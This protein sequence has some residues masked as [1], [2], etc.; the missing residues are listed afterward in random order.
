MVGAKLRKPFHGI[1]AEKKAGTMKSGVAVDKKKKMVKRKE[2]YSLYIYK[3]LTQA[4]PDSGITT[5]AMGIM[6]SF[7]SDI[8]E[9]T[10]KEASR[11]TKNAKKSAMSSREIQTTVGGFYQLAWTN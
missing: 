10:A 5:I 3:V 8:F 11:L 2:S 6:K 7:V 4:H 9:L 1:S